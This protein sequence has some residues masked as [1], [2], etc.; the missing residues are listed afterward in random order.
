MNANHDEALDFAY[1]HCEE[2]NLAKCYIEL[3]AKYNKE[4]FTDIQIREIWDGL[5]IKMKFSKY[6]LNFAHALIAR[7]KL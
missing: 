4:L 5:N 7:R 3:H 2:S 6:L 1:L